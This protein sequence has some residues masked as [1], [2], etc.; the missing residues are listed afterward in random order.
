MG[1]ELLLPNPKGDQDRRPGFRKFFDPS[2]GRHGGLEDASDQERR[3][4]FCEFFDPSDRSRVFLQDAPYLFEDGVSLGS[5]L[6]V[7]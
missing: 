2:D 7:R 1:G 6:R 4:D 3:P 5:I